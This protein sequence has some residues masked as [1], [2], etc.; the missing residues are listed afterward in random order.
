MENAINFSVGVILPAAGSGERLGND[1]P[2]QYYEIQG[3]P[4][5]LYAVEALENIPWVVQIVLVSDNVEKM[6]SILTKRKRKTIDKVTV[7]K[8]GSTRHRSIQA[9][10]KTITESAG[11][12]EILV[13]HDAVRPLVPVALLKQLV[14]TAYSGT[15]A[16]GLT[17]PLISTVLCTDQDSFLAETLDRSKFLNSETP[18]AFKTSVLSEAYQKVEELER[19]TECLQ[20]VL[21]HCGVRAKLLEGND[22]LWKVTI[23]RDLHSAIGCITGK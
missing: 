15:G 10:L 13:V 8:G 6:Q 18:Q 1:P 17:R 23:P 3:K 19:G 9:G 14:Q 12:C 5:F 22:D 7:I 21:K 2:K 11:R 20:L 16:A 4:L